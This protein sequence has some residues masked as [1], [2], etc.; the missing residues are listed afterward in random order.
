[1]N[2]IK[3]NSAQSGD[4]C[5][6]QH[7]TVTKNQRNL[8]QIYAKAMAH[9]LRQFSTC[10]R[11]Q[12]ASEN[13][14]R[15]RFEL[16]RYMIR[17]YEINCLRILKA[18]RVPVTTKLKNTTLKH[19]IKEKPIIFRYFSTPGHETKKIKRISIQY[20]FSIVYSTAWTIFTCLCRTSVRS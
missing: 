3:L 9:G 17:L 6:F 20:L 5:H 16:M 7:Y 13:F 2:C 10:I 19:V 4:Y 14:C 12:V 11:Y 18:S 8:T 1:M 15:V